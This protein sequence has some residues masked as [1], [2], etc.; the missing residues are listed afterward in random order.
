ML[1][2]SIHGGKIYDLR[3]VLLKTVKATLIAKYY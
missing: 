3:E 1:A 2:I